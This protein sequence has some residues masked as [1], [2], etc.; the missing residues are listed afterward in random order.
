MTDPGDRSKSGALGSALLVDP[1]GILFFFLV[2][3]IVR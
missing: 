1:D 2:A 3:F